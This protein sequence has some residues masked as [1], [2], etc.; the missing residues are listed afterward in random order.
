MRSLAFITLALSA[1]TPT[2]SNITGPPQL[3]SPGAKPP[4]FAKYDP[5]GDSEMAPTWTRRF[6]LSGVSFDQRQTA[7]LISRRH[8]VMA[9]HF[10][11]KRGDQVIFHDRSGKRIARTLIDLKPVWGDVAVGLL[12]SDV[13]ASLR[14]YPLPTPSTEYRKLIGRIAVVT[15]QH[16]GLFFHEVQGAA[17]GS[18][19]LRHDLQERHGYYVNLVSGDSGNPSFLLV[20]G[21][22]VLIETHT[23]GG[24]GGGPYYG[25]PELQQKLQQ[26]MDELAP[27]YRLKLRRL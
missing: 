23:F 21:E 3:P 11:R 16:R 24:G 17:N 25:W 7:T 14:I 6:D 22:L 4:I 5:A 13:P 12:D 20:N 19:S 1:C 26:R 8:V 27:G 18:L 2:P 9:Q 15:N 10:V